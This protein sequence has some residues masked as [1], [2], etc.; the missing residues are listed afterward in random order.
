MRSTTGVP[1]E[2]EWNVRSAITSPSADCPLGTIR[3]TSYR[4]P[5]SIAPRRD[6]WLRLA[7]LELRRPVPDGPRRRI[8][9][10]CPVP[11][12][13][14]WLGQP[15]AEFKRSSWLRML[16]RRSR[17]SALFSRVTAPGWPSPGHGVRSRRSVAS[18]LAE[19]VRRSPG[20]N[21]SS[22]QYP[23]R[24]RHPQASPPNEHQQPIG[25]HAHLLRCSVSAIGL[26]RRPDYSS[27]PGSDAIQASEGS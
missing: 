19:T 11:I 8:E 6:G 22:R 3:R 4:D 16:S 27:R 17:T 15:P 7:V 9:P 2:P 14:H 26:G 25:A 21:S 24:H 23:P 18:P 20:A 5:S 10:D 12:R 1:S 13:A